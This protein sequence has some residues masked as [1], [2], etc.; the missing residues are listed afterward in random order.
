MDNLVWWF[1]ETNRAIDGRLRFEGKWRRSFLW[2][3]Y[4][5][6]GS[7]FLGSGA[8]PLSVCPGETDGSLVQAAPILG[9]A[10]L[11]LGVSGDC[12][13]RHERF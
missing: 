13:G 6:F 5:L 12:T 3:A 10:E 2:E 9:A 4:P 7:K 8:S 11:R 1:G